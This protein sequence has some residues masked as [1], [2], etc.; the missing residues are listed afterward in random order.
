MT[1]I[2][3]HSFTWY[4]QNRYGPDQ[5]KYSA[6]C[7]YF[8]DKSTEMKVEV[9]LPIALATQLDSLGQKALWEKIVQMKKE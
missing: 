6:T 2:K 9:E 7:T 8:V 5:A 3:L 1:D 4:K